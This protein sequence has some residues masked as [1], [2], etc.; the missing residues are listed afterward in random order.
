MN[1][2]VLR[3]YQDGFYIHLSGLLTILATMQVR[4]LMAGE[5]GKVRRGRLVNR[6]LT[7]Y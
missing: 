5:A 3:G 2:N 7:R 1:I 6:P 4:L